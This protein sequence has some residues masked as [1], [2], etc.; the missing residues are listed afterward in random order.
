MVYC[1]ASLYYMLQVPK[2]ETNPSS[3]SVFFVFLLLIENELILTSAVPSL[4]FPSQ[5][6]TWCKENSYIIAGYYQANERTKDSR[7]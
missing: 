4:L 5:I 7:Y 6:D 2:L 1:R 3:V